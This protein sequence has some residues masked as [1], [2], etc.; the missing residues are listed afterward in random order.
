MQNNNNQPKTA[1]ELYKKI[2]TQNLSKEA[3]RTAWIKEIANMD[4]CNDDAFNENNDLCQ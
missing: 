4:E 2:S 3:L 1:E